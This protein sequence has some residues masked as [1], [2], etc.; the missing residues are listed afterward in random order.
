MHYK[1]STSLASDLIWLAIDRET[2]VSDSVSG[3]T[4]SAASRKRTFVSVAESEQRNTDETIKISNSSKR[5]VIFL[6]CM[7]SR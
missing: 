6:I 1:G 5:V 4:S 2:G 7:H 3:L